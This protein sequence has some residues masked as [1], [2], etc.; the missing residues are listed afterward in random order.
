MGLQ[1]TR[2][3][4]ANQERLEDAV[5]A[6]GGKVVGVQQRRTRVVQITVERDH[7]RGLARH[8]QEL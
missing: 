6:D 5:A 7:D 4:V 1:E 8:G 2:Q 3:A